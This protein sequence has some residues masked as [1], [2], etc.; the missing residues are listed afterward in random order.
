MDLLKAAILVKLTKLGKPFHKLM[1][2]QA[3]KLTLTILLLGL[4][5]SQWSQI[6]CLP[7]HTC[8]CG[9][10]ANLECRY[11]TC[12]TWLAENTGCKNYAKKSLFAHHRTRLSGYIF[13]NK[14][15][16]DNRKNLLNSNMVNFGPLAAEIGW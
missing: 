7:Y 5:S 15:R 3:K 4:K 16:I 1:T 11:E 6:G 8:C 13:A 9:L 10:S 12:C 2:L 14:T